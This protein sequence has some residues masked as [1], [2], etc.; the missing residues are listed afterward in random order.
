MVVPVAVYTNVGLVTEVIVRVKSS[1]T[2]MLL[3]TVT[4]TETVVVELMPMLN[5][6]GVN[7]VVGQLLP[8]RV[9]L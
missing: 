9:T 3:G 5:D 7:K 2:L 4:C 6:D 8:E 1:L